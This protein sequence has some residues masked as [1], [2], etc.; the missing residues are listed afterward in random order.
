MLAF[1]GAKRTAFVGHS[2]GCTLVQLLLAD[3]PQYNDRVT[4]ALHLG[5]VMAVELFRGPFLRSGASRS[6][7]QVRVCV[8]VCVWCFF[9]VAGR[10]GLAAAAAARRGAQHGT[11]R[12]PTHPTHTH[13]HRHP[14]C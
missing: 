11:A 5:P 13:R 9:L 12:L 1:T 8:C 7:D 6:L 2:Q 14:R 4:A 3:Q 10:V